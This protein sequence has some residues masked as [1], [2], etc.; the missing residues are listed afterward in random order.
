MWYLPGTKPVPPQK[1]VKGVDGQIYTVPLPLTSEFFESIGWK[2]APPQPTVNFLYCLIDWDVDDEKWTPLVKSYETRKAIFE[3]HRTC[4]I[5][6]IRAYIKEA[7][8]E[9]LDPSLPPAM[10]PMVEEQYKGYFEEISELSSINYQD[11]SI[12]ELLSKFETY[13]LAVQQDEQQNTDALRLYNYTK[14]YNLKSQPP[15]S[16]V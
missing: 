14:I 15:R 1:E 16:Y 4:L 6:A 11:S 12:D 8:N 5:N 10:R 3:E 9:V 7:R 2:E 13:D